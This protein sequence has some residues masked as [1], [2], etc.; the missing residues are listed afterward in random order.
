MN[1]IKII[2]KHYIV[3][4][5]LIL[6]GYSD[7]NVEY[8]NILINPDQIAFIDIEDNSI[9]MSSGHTFDLKKGQIQ[10]LGLN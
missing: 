9:T 2:V 10:K 1:L 3:E 6:N 4:P 8:I 5:D 7:S